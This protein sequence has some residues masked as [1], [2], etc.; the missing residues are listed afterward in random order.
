MSAT[1]ETST[2]ACRV[3][4]LTKTYGTGQAEVRALDDV[5]VDPGSQGRGIGAR[6]LAALAAR[7]REDG[8]LRIDTA[9]HR[10]NVRAWRFYERQGYRPLDEERIS[11]LL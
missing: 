7:L 1:P 6:M 4:N 10:Q 3:R 2:I 8:F 11:L 9:C 5:T